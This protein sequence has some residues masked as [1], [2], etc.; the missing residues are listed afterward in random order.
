MLSV[1][2]ENEAFGRHSWSPVRR[3]AGEDHGVV[4]KPGFL[5]ADLVLAAYFTVTV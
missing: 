2:T 4:A 3:P 5:R 1:F